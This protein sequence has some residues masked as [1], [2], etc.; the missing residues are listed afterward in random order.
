MSLTSAN[1]GRGVDIVSVVF[2]RATCSSACRHN[3]CPLV[4]FNVHVRTREAE[5]RLHRR[6]CTRYE[7][8]T[9]KDKDPAIQM[10]L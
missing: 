8:Q 3:R 1:Q 4:G 7:L 2:N 5:D 6:H 10:K 9:Y